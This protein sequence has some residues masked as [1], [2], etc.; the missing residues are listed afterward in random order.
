METRI[1]R[2]EGVLN[3]RPVR[4][5]A[6]RDTGRQLCTTEKKLRVELFRKVSLE[7]T[8]A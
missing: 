7:R 8:T 3:M 4:R 6:A 1:S 5:P 2:L